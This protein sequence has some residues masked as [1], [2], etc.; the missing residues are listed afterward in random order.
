MPKK[1]ITQQTIEDYA[2]KDWAIEKKIDYMLDYISYVSRYSYRNRYYA[3]KFFMEW[4]L[5]QNVRDIHLAEI[6]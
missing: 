1:L 3:Q 4:L 5:Q 6:L 2:N